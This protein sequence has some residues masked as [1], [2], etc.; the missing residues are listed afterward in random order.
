MIV[1]DT[2]VLSELT[3]ARPEASVLAWLDG[4]DPEELAT[5]AITVAEL[6]F[7]VELLP[8][9]RREDEIRA[10]VFEILAEELDIEPFDESSAR[11]YAQPAAH[12]RQAGKPVS[13]ADGQI[14]AICHSLDATL[15]TRNVDDFAGFGIHVV[16]PWTH[17]IK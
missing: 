7:G 2:N 1:L 15:A 5:T 11:A 12:R 8:N 10:A 4:C 13:L 6:C 3:R 16:N 14:A 17:P 9:G